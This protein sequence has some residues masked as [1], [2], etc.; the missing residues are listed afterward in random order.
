MKVTNSTAAYRSS[1]AFAQIGRTCGALSCPEP[2][3]LPLIVKVQALRGNRNVLPR[4]RGTL[5]TFMAQ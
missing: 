5:V 4:R 2:T 3:H 1:L